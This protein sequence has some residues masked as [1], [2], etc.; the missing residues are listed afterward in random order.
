MLVG[1][2]IDKLLAFLAELLQKIVCVWHHCKPLIVFWNFQEIF[3]CNVYEEA[4]ELANWP[5]AAVFVHI[6]READRNITRGELGASFWRV[7]FQRLLLT[8]LNF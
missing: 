8:V 3:L 1:K 7:T 2:I 5:T 6:F 4:E